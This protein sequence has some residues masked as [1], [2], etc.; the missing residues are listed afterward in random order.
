MLAGWGELYGRTG[1]NYIFSGECEAVS[2]VTKET[3]PATKNSPP[4]TVAGVEGASKL[5][6]D[7]GSSFIS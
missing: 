3:S 5:G 4:A 2:S 6:R 1:Y 7:Y